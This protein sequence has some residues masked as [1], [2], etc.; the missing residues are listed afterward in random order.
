MMKTA[1]FYRTADGFWR[2]KIP[3]DLRE[4]LGLNT[5]PKGFRPLLKVTIEFD[6]EHE[7]SPGT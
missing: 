3:M 4:G 7:P 6:P 1:T 2:I 5:Y